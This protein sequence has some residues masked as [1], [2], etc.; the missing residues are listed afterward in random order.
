MKDIF[1]YPPNQRKRVAVIRFRL[2]QGED[3]FE[4]LLKRLDLTEEEFTN[5][6]GE[7]LIGNPAMFNDEIVEIIKEAF[8]RRSIG[9]SKQ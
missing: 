6:Y 9:G 3:L 4:K 5:E 2:I 1:D 7:Q 8:K